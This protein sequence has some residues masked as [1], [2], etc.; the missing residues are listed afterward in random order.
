MNKFVHLHTH[1]H[2]S[3]LDGLSK[4]DA[5]IDKA[6]SLGMEAL[7]IT[8]H[9][10]L[11][12]SVEF[13]QKAKKAGTK[14]IIGMEGYVAQRSRHD[15]EPGK[16]SERYHLTLLVKNEMGYKN[17]VQ[18]ATK[19]HLEGFYYKPRMD[20]EL[21][22]AHHE[23]LICLSGCPA[24]ELSRALEHGE[25]TKAYEIA[26]YYKR[27]FGDDYY[28]EIQPQTKFNQ[29]DLTE[30]AQEL[31]IKVVATQDSHYVERA[32]QP[33]HDILLAIQTGNKID[34]ESRFNF[35]G[36][37]AFF[38]SAEEMLELFKEGGMAIDEKSALEAIDNTAEV[39]EKCNFDFKLKQLHLPKY[40]LPQGEKN[41]IEYL[42]KLVNGGIKERFGKADKA[43]QDRIEHE[44]AIIQ[45]TGFED[46]FLIVQDL[47]NWAKD[48][49]IM[50]GPGR[51]SAAGSLVS[52]LLNITEVDPLKYGLL[53][54]RFLNPER[55]EMPDIDL[56]F[57]DNRRDEVFGYL[58]EKY[59][60]DHVAQII[61]FGTMAARQ[62]VRDAGR[63]MGLPYS[64]CDQIAK[65]IPFNP[66]QGRPKSEIETYLQTIPE[67]KQIADSDPKAKELLQMAS[68]LEGVARHASVHACGTVV[69][70]KPITEYLAIQRAPQDDNTIITQVEMHGVEDLGLLKIDLL[71]LRN[72]TIIQ[73]TIRL[74]KELRDETI[75]VSQ[76]PLNDQATFEFLRTGETVGIFQ[77]ESSGMRRYMKEI[78]PSELEDLT[79]LV[80]LYRPGPMELIPSYIKRKWGEE[81]V[82][83]I[84][85]SLEPILKSTY[86]IGV[87][88]EQMMKI[89]TDLAGYT[90]PEADTLRKAIGKKIKKLLDEQK[91]KL[92]TGMIQGGIDKKTAE[93]I[94]DLFPPFARYG[95]NR[96]HAVSYALIGYWTAYL[97]THYP[98][99]F[100]TSILNHTGNDIERTAFFIQEAERMG[101]KVLPPDINNSVAHFAPEGANI[102]FG[103][104]AIKN[105][106]LAL[107][108]RLVEE[109]L[110]GGPFEG[111]ADLALRAR[112]YG[113]NKKSLESLTKSG[114]LDSFGIDRA[115]AL[116]NVDSVLRAA[117]ESNSGNGSRGLFGGVHKFEIKLQPA[118][119]TVTK[120]E[121]L[122]WEKE[123]LGLY[124]TE[125][126]LKQYFE[127]NGG[128]AVKTIKSIKKDGK[129][130]AE[131]KVCGVVSVVK[132]II[133]KSGQPMAFATIEDLG[134]TI[135][136]LVF[137]DVLA[138]TGSLWEI[139]KAVN[140]SGRT[141]MRDGEAKIICQNVKEVSL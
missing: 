31:D 28:I 108:E 78:K 107:T 104:S 110:K 24:G 26:K 97:K 103:L 9:G 109:R 123:L 21:L 81:K 131:V 90:L 1:S 14:P 4:I 12:G 37:M 22:E 82:V 76:I 2:Y 101:I 115:T 113:L 66:N 59:G 71:G 112:P 32:D 39:S 62:A 23:G 47:V 136:V 93:K 74:I 44:L 139:N 53:F 140:I 79:A 124:V 111:L 13:Y 51:G 29:K 52:Y 10:N 18:L 56:D 7:A 27:L 8:D 50:V 77:F 133:T 106:G 92:V 126:P 63:A 128:D 19:A 40:Q 43:I 65:L 95:F 35:G 118:N 72:L 129:E 116:E 96:S 61:T 60:E 11:Y 88:Q 30:L 85:P 41:S 36:Y 120:A 6:K 84:H 70:E 132:K 42:R 57:A 102:R 135:E 17:L 25:K 137:S 99:E 49:G 125:H 34:D 89:A 20:R 100:I 91:E 134:D 54:E 121:K 122:G 64:F 98:E 38:A 48:R 3:L 33:T 45:K 114:A 105:V 83:Y 75:R 138:R 55:N 68:H 87:Y 67:L 69:T 5:L 119:R 16:D 127:K 117:G 58:R 46:Y 86:G 94:W 141:S 130:G 73:E 80:A 15:K